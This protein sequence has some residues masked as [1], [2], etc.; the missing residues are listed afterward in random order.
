MGS[1]WGHTPLRD[2]VNSDSA[3]SLP[4]S[5]VNWLWMQR[6][7][8]M[9]RLKSSKPAVQCPVTGWSPNLYSFNWLNTPLT[10]PPVTCLRSAKPRLLSALGDNDFKKEQVVMWRKGKREQPE[11]VRPHGAPQGCS[12]DLYVSR[13]TKSFHWGSLQ[14]P[15]A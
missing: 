7:N 1:A 11:K 12:A 6:V 5:S 9:K 15:Q 4:F 14:Q 13:F 3:S 2:K 8:K 10:P